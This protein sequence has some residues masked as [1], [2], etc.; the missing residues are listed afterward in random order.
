MV[1]QLLRLRTPPAAG[2]RG[3]RRRGRAHAPAHRHAPGG[4]LPPGHRARDDRHGDRACSP[5]RAGDTL[6]VQTDGGV[7]YAVTVP[8][9]VAERLPARGRPGEPPHR[10][11]GEGGRLGALRLRPPGASG[12]C[13]SGCSA[14]AASAPSW[15]SPCS[16]RSGPERT[17]RSIRARDL[18]ALSSVSGIGRKKAERLVLELQ[19]RFG[20]VPL[21]RRPPR[22]AGCRGGGAGADGP[23]LRPRRRR[24]R[25]AGR[26]GR[27]RT[28]RT[29][30]AHPAGASAARR[31]PGRAMSRHERSRRDRR[32]DLHPLR[33]H[34]PQA[35]AR[36]TTARPPTAASPCRARTSIE[37]DDRPVRWNAQLESRSRCHDP[38]SR[39]HHSRGPPRRDRAPMRRSG[40]RGWTS[41][42]ARRR[43]RPRS[44][45]P[46][47]RRKRRRETLDHTLFFGPPGLGKTTL[48]MLMAREM[49]VQLRTTSGPVLEKPGDLVGLLT[50]LGA[51]RHALHRR[52]PPAQAGA[53]GVSLS[54]HGR[55][56]GG[57][58]D[59][60]RPQR[61]DD[62]DGARA[63]HPD[64]RH[65]PVRPA[66]PADAGPVRHRR[67][68]RLLSRRRAA[69]DRDPLGRRSSACRSRRRARRRSPG[70]AGARRGW[71]TGCCAGSATTPR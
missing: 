24:R 3:R 15:R 68:A 5:S 12:R 58:A 55:L 71:P 61:P 69:A 67:A 35:R 21:E 34:Q 51:G 66:H 65:D 9:G 32:V 50:S 17:V 44:R 40:R 29:P 38:A 43:S 30:A 36:R 33:H 13:S 47:T 22:A 54:G 46:S 39:S 31:R 42:S 25:G 28:A 7:G 18:A 49:G 27:R 19:D 53:G 6:V 14:P 57:R 23:G 64:R 20:D 59:R 26:A 45:S 60:R 48:A 70:G 56:P 62:P 11:G 8:A 16:R 37:P 63:V 52:D 4:V 2:G 41:S 10:A 1:A